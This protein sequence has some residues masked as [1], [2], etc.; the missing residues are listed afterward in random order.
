MGRKRKK[1]PRPKRTALWIFFI[2]LV[3]ASALFWWLR[4]HLFPPSPHFNFLLIEKND[5]AL[6][7]LKGEVLN[8]NPRDLFRIKKISSN[9]FISQ[10]FRLYAAEFDI[11]AFL[12]DKLV[13]SDFLPQEDVFNRYD[14]NV[15]VKYRHRTLGH[16][17]LRIEPDLEDWL[18]KADRTIDKGRKI[19]LLEK[20]LAYSPG[21]FRLE[22]KLIEAYK[23]HRQ[24]SKAA[25]MLEKMADKT[26]EEKTL[27]D[28][29]EVYEAMSD[30]KGVVS[31]MR[32]LIKQNPGDAA[33]KIRLADLMETSGKLAEA[34]IAYEGALNDTDKKERAPLYKTLGYLCRVSMIFCEIVSI[35]LPIFVSNSLI[36]DHI[37]RG[38]SS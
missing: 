4:P 16:V 27:N 14:I 1:K 2:F 21:D 18:A 37:S 17:T 29:L 11:N 5:Q 6:K 24:W 31:V 38:M 34:V 8:M 33:L 35:L 10:G 15:E 25:A 12:H 13:I 3:G 9:R 30:Q 7:L 36:N 20:A 32:R 28:L 19:S 26:P 23:S 22:E